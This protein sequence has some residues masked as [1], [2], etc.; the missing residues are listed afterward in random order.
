V[1]N[2]WIN[3]DADVLQGRLYGVAGESRPGDTACFVLLPVVGEML[4]TSRALIRLW[5]ARNNQLLCFI[6]LWC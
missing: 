1:P 2:I 6:G 3:G 5:F 4:V